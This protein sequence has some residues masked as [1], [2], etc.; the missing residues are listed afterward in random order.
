MKIEIIHQH[1]HHHHFDEALADAFRQLGSQIGDVKRKMETI[2]MDTS[3][4]LAAVEREKTESASL[5]AL[6]EAQTKAMVEVKE[7]LA[8][9]VSKLD[10]QGANTQEL[11]KVQ[12]DIDQAVNDLSADSDKAE[13]AIKANSSGDQQQAGQQQSGGQQQSDQGS[14]GAGQSSGDQSGSSGAQ[15]LAGTSAPQNPS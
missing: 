3:K 7:K 2:E 11:E 1:H 8:D 10:S 14:Q 4:L 15:P 5:R 9:A 6:V 12:R 13:A